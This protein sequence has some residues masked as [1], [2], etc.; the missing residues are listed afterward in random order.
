MLEL[1]KIIKRYGGTAVLDRIDLSIEEGRCTVLLGPSGSGKTTL[2]RLLVGLVW[3]DE[4]QILIGGQVLH[5]S[6]LREHRLGLGLVQQEGGLFPHLTARD[7]LRLLP[8]D[9]GWE[10]AR[11][12]ARIEELREL[13][14]LPSDAMERHPGRLSGGQVQRV[15]LMRALILD[16][17]LLLFD[18]PLGAL[19]PM[20]RYDLQGD[21][22][23]IFSE[24][25]KTVVLVTHD[26]AEAAFFADR[27]VLLR[28]GRI[29]QLGSLHDL[30]DHP[31]NDFVT[32]FVRAQ[33]SPLGGAAGQEE[34]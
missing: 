15:A 16:P 3:P 10:P 5:E 6:H 24:L 17:P 1:R 8:R 13:V 27:I 7:N 31:A 11:I 18:E 25:R 34:A 30:L 23:R 9:L 21:L 33:R 29:A 28:E 32:A 19:D 22:A 20:I 4:G 26:L 14:S 12:E 2:L